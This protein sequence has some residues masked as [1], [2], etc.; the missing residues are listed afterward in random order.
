LTPCET[1]VET[2]AHNELRDLVL[3]KPNDEEPRR[4]S[5]TPEMVAKHDLSTASPPPDSLFWTMWN[6]CTDVAADNWR[7][8]IET[9]EK[10]VD[11]FP[12]R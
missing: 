7:H 5:L 3:Q 10:I 8:D 4:I 6:A 11:E 12:L 9:C 1:A 2:R